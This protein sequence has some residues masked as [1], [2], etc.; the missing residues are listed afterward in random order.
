MVVTPSQAIM[1]RSD[2]RMESVTTIG[3]SSDLVIEV[4]L[5]LK[6]GSCVSEDLGLILAVSDAHI[7][8]EMSDQLRLANVV[9]F[10]EFGLLLIETLEH[11][12]VVGGRINHAHVVH[13]LGLLEIFVSIVDFSAGGSIEVVWGQSEGLCPCGS[14]HLILNCII[15]INLL[16]MTAC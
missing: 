15:I 11:G 2:V 1:L 6:L 4:L 5:L 14:L 13:L 12:L 7:V 16:L 3:Q 8:S 9:L 10:V